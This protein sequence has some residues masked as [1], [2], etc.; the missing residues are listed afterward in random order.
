MAFN[1]STDAASVGVMKMT[2]PLPH[3]PPPKKINYYHTP[4]ISGPKSP[5]EAPNLLGINMKCHLPETSLCVNMHE[6]WDQ[7]FGHFEEMR[8]I[9]ELTSMKNSR[10]NCLKTELHYLQVQQIWFHQNLYKLDLQEI[11][12]Q[13]SIRPC[14]P[15]KTQTKNPKDL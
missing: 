6:K 9:R 7:E 14:P 11:W 12:V 4:K 2:P 3:P 13:K 15:K 5:P 8:F 1:M 10:I